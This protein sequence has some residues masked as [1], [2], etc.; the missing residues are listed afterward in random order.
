M[1][2][3]SIEG[4][5]QSMPSSYAF[6]NAFNNS[7]ITFSIVDNAIALV[8]IDETFNESYAP[9]CNSNNLRPVMCGISFCLTR[10]SQ[11]AETCRMNV[12]LT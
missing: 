10:H 4:V 2:A 8:L 5:V 12:S 11:E 9:S 6:P 7:L 3:D 1:L